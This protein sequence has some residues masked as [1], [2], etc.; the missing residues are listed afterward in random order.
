MD[1]H[2]GIT[3]YIVTITFAPAL[4]A[5][6][7]DSEL[8]ILCSRG[9]TRQGS[10]WHLVHLSQAGICGVSPGASGAHVPELAHLV[11]A[12]ASV[13]KETDI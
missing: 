8:G 6:Q 13:E 1:K 10:N 5:H 4:G 7:T 11:G 12:S 3:G 2:A 9:V